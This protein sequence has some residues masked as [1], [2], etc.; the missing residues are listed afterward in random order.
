MTDTI[1]MMSVDQVKFR[2]TPRHLAVLVGL[3]NLKIHVESLICLDSLNQANRQDMLAV[4]KWLKKNN[5]PPLFFSANPTPVEDKS[6]SLCDHLLKTWYWG[7][8]ECEF[9]LRLEGLPLFK[10]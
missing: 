1:Q 5:F 7:E 8:K 9:V 2:L 4:E 3:R 10:T 6:S